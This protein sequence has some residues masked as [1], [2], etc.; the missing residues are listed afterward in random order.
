MSRHGLCDACIY[1]TRGGLPYLLVRCRNCQEAW[2][3]RTRAGL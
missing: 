3:R 1:K 2:R